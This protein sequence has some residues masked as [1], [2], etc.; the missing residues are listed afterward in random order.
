MFII[1]NRLERDL[2]H[3]VSTCG[4]GPIQ[5]SKT[6]GLP[7]LFT[8]ETTQTGRQDTL[9]LMSGVLIRVPIMGAARTLY[10]IG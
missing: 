1:I 10:V 6:S 5:S 4:E 9:F 8:P 3:I 7:G 2:T